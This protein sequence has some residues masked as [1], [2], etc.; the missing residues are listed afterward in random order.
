MAILIP[1]FFREETVQTEHHDAPRYAVA[2]ATSGRS[3][4]EA[5]F[6]NHTDMEVG[7]IETLVGRSAPIQFTLD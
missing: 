5:P 1:K 2:R 7:L 6:K 3:V 4:R